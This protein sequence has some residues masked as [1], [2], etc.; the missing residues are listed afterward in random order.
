MEW[1]LFLSLIFLMLALDLGV[2]NKKSHNVSFKE[3]MMWTFVWISLALIFN[4]WIY[5][6][7]GQT[8]AL[9]FLSGYLIEKSLSIDNIF[10]FIIV[11]SAFKVQK[12]DQHKILFYG[13]LSALVMRAI[14]IF[15]GI[16][17][18]AKFH[19]LIY[20][21][22]LFLIFTGIKLWKESDSDKSDNKIVNWINKNLKLKHNNEHFFIKENGKTYLTTAFGCLLA[23]EITDLVFA[24]DSIPAILA[25]TQ[26]P[27]IV[28]T[29]N[30]FAILGLRSLYF[31]LA[32]ILDLFKYLHYGL[33][34]ILVFVGLKMMMMDVFKIPPM[35]S[36]LVIFS[37]LTISISMS[38]FVKKK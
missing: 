34:V 1:I 12:K 6:S 13:I 20:I 2:F 5:Y 29:S 18:L 26:D 35:V 36:L 16:E 33:S 31:A 32:G 11:F 4:I 17:L 27:Y 8:L 25:V 19:W 28:F 23:I 30:I 15:A 7:K 37:I 21:F 24:V 3:A 38:F 9:E 10:V 14:F 22:G